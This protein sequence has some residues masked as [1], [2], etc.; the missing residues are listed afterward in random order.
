MLVTEI[1]HLLLPPSKQLTAPFHHEAL[2]PGKLAMR[3]HGVRPT[4]ATKAH[5]LAG[6][7]QHGFEGGRSLVLA[8]SPSAYFRYFPRIVLGISERGLEC[9]G[10]MV[11]VRD[12]SQHFPLC[13]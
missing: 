5:D 6:L 9:V 3:R 11:H 12:W 10:Q 13:F 1:L 2:Y 4:E 7:L 8:S